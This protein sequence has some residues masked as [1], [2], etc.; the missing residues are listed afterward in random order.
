MSVQETVKKQIE[1]EDWVNAKHIK[2]NTITDAT[3]YIT[4]I[5]EELNEGYSFKKNAM[6]NLVNAMIELLN[7]IAV[8]A[9][10][11]DKNDE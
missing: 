6:V 4:R 1:N 10:E 8:P 11:G 7:G 5:R 2:L 9:E 3:R